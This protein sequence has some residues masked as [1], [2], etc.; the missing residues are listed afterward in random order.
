MEHEQKE[1]PMS[2][3][4]QTLPHNAVTPR[5]RKLR[6]TALIAVPLIAAAILV[7]C[8]GGS[9]GTTPP[10]PAPTY[11]VGGT[12]TGLSG[13]LVLQNNAGNDA[14]ISANGGFTFTTALNSGAA[15]AVTVKTQPSTAS[16]AQNCV[17]TG[18]AGSVGGSNVTNVSVA[19]VTT[20]INGIT[21][22]PPPGTANDSTIAGIDSDNNGIRDD[23]DIFIATKYGTNPTA[24]AGAKRATK[25]LQK[26]LTTNPLQA[27]QARLALQDIGDAGVCAG[28]A[29][30]SVNL[31][32]QQELNEIYLRSLSTAERL[33]HDRRVSAAGGLFERSVLAAVCQ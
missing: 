2:Q 26:I 10:P 28:R 19:C 22:P 29:F 15:Y 16:L 7:A 33:A 17:V 14:T 13:S 11:T 21:V 24:Y 23:I 8:G 1:T 31:N 9:G 6:R 3:E 25:A 18:G 27:D 4:S 5:S 30:R 32:S 12:V 20:A